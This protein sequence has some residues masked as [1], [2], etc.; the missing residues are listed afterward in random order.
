MYTITLED[1]PASI[2]EQAKLNAEHNFQ[3]VLEPDFSD[4]EDL[5]HAYQT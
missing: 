2:T 1:C 3:R 4:P 5:L